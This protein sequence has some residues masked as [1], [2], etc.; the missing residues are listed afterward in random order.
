MFLLIPLAEPVRP[1]HREPAPQTG[2]AEEFGGDSEAGAG[3]DSR[4]GGR[5][6]ASY[7]LGWNE[8]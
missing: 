4:A 3:L 8:E 7:Q 6:L 1:V 2:A 5:L